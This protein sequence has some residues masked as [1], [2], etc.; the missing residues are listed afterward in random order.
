MLLLTLCTVLVSGLRLSHIIIHELEF[1]DKVTLQAKTDFTL[2]G[3]MIVRVR[4][5]IW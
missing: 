3:A 2:L 4:Y 1:P 5:K